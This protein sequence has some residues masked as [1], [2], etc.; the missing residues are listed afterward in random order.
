MIPQAT[1]SCAVQLLDATKIFG[2]NGHRTRAV[3]HVSFRALAGELVLLL[4]PS[5]SGKTTLLTMAAGLLKPTSGAVVLFG[6]NIE[7]YSS[8]E[9][10]QLRATHIGFV[11]QTFHLI[12]SLSVVENV[13][14]VPRFA[15]KSKREA[16]ER[17]DC[18]LRRLQIQ[19]LE[20]KFPPELSQGEKQRAAVARAIVN[21]A[22]LIIADEPTASLETK[23]GLDIIRV[24]HEYAKTQHR[25]VIVASHDLRIM[26]FADRVLRLQDG[27][28][29]GAQRKTSR[30]LPGSR[31]FM[32][33]PRKTSM[34]K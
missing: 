2:A 15:G 4:G 18:L 7:T 26:A 14:L 11:F 23:Q 10:Q 16:R 31:V 20:T 17:A 8:R 6:R 12:D 3:R 34:T 21:D 9:L 25:C 19:H 33:L 13:A 30:F 22:A 32:D 27:E 29:V 1:E 28:L 5:G 24:L